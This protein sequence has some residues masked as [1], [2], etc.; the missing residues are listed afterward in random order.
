MPGR[1]SSPAPDWRLVRPDLHRAVRGGRGG[2]LAV[3]GAPPHRAPGNWLGR[4]PRHAAAPVRGVPH[5]GVMLALAAVAAG[6]GYLAAGPQGALG[7]TCGGIV[8]AGGPL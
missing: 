4:S 3:D 8:S 6:I 5:G 7:R 2:H 1:R